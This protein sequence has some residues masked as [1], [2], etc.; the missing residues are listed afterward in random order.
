MYI[1]QNFVDESGYFAAFTLPFILQQ[2]NTFLKVLNKRNK[3]NQII[4][5]YIL[6]VCSNFIFMIVNP[7]I[8]ANYNALIIL[9]KEMKLLKYSE[10]QKRKSFICTE[11]FYLRNLTEELV[12]GNQ[13]WLSTMVLITPWARLFHFLIIFEA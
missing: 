1:C 6:K 9:P 3:M 11:K 13:S 12:L 2:K 4:V 8:Y 7:R 10:W 5:F